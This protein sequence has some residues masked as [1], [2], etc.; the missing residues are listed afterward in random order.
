MTEQERIIALGALKII[1]PFLEELTLD[2]IRSLVNGRVDNIVSSQKARKWSPTHQGDPANDW[3]GDILAKQAD[4]ALFVMAQQAPGLFTDK[5]RDGMSP[6]VTPGVRA[7]IDENSTYEE[8]AQAAAD[9]VNRVF[10]QVVQA[11][12]P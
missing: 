10:E 6:L 1:T 11:V 3:P 2:G 12:T 4:D 8:I 5:F 9:G 7:K